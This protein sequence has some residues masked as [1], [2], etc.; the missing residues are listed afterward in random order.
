MM[1]YGLVVNRELRCVQWFN[2]PPLIWDF[3]LGFFSSDHEYDVVE[4]NPVIVGHVPACD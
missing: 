2:N 1:W 3:H 4:V